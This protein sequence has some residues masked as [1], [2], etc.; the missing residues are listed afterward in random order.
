MKLRAFFCVIMISMMPFLGFCSCKENVEEHPTQQN[1]VQIKVLNSNNIHDYLS[2]SVTEAETSDGVEK[3][4]SIFPLRA[5]VFENLT[6]T[7][8]LTKQSAWTALVDAGG[9]WTR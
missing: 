7:F 4:L 3:S 6:L 2:I 9:T 8:K 1:S 5:G